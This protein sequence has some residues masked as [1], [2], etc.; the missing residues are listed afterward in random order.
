M[1]RTLIGVAAAAMHAAAMP[2]A[3]APGLLRHLAGVP[4]T[5]QG[6]HAAAAPGD[7]LTAERRAAIW[8]RLL[9]NREALGARLPAPAG[10]SAPVLVWPV[11]A[12]ARTSD[13]GVHAV[14][15]FVDHEPS[16][17]NQLL[18]YHCGQR[19]YDTASGYN[20]GGIDILSWPWP[21]LKMS[22]GDVEAIAAAPGVILGR[23]DGHADQSCSLNGNDW[24]AV[25]VQHAD[26]S[27][28]WYGH[29]KNGSVTA[30]GIGEPVAR[31]EVLGVVGSSGN[32]TGPHL[33]FEL[34][35]A[36][37]RLT[38]PFDGSCNALPAPWWKAQKPYHDSAINQVTT[39]GAAPVVPA[40]P[41]VE[42]PN[43]RDSFAAGERIYFSTY[44]RDLLA[45]QPSTYT[46]RRPDGSVFSSWSHSSPA[47]HYAASTWY[48]YFDMPAN[49]PA[50][51]WRFTVDYLG[52]STDRYFNI[53]SP[54]SVKVKVPNGGE[55][56]TRGSK[57]SVRWVANLGG[58][59]RI[60][61]HRNGKFIQ[62]LA[63]S[64]PNDTTH[65]WTIPTNLPVSPKYR[66]RIVDLADETVYDDSNANF[67]LE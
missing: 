27:V 40:C 21:W 43:I 33:H 8:Q 28:A 47:P 54:T 17:P 9:R 37:G 11:R 13:P 53:G 5:G 36:Q 31:N 7:E 45:S 42:S 63:A 10:S 22:R 25:Y 6:F 3:D 46:I 30:K 26:G 44:Y 61:L 20:H 57:V 38:D 14:S 60:E 29:L 39:G 59:V 16:A 66:I 34:Y 56:W 23:D 52:A 35:D 64:T 4:P 49:V 58:P 1:R 19:T 12:S 50:G 41:G 62:T 55:V 15:N 18:D 48:W 2:A 51:I 24:N 65:G 32:S 67:T